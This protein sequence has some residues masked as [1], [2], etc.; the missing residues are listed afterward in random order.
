MDR[1]DDCKAKLERVE[2]ALDHKEPDRV[3][4]SDFFWQ[5]F[6]EEWRR[7]KN[8]T[9][10]TDIPPWIVTVDT[11]YRDFPLY[12]SLCEGYETLWRI[13]GSENGYDYLGRCGV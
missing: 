13:I 4:I 10:E 3:P 9:A 7:K 2:R 12:G 6:I 5:G 11:Y 1:T 8:L